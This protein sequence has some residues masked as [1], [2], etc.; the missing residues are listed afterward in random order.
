MR[1]DVG[2]HD[3]AECLTYF[4]YRRIVLEGTISLSLFL[5]VIA[6]TALRIE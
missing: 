2:R 6:G 4:N 1:I 3:L 5:F